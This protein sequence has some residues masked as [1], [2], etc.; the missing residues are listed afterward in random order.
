LKSKTTLNTMEFKGKYIRLIPLKMGHAEA[1]TKAANIFREIFPLS[2]VP[3][4]VDS[5][6]RCI[7][8]ANYLCTERS[9]IPFAIVE[10]FNKKI[11]G[12]TG[13]LNLE[14]WDFPTGHKLRRT[15][16][17]PT[18]VEIGS[19]YLVEPDQSPKIIFDAKLCLLTHAFEEWEVL[20]VAFKTDARNKQSRIN[21]ERIGAKF[22]GVIRAHRQ[23]YG[24]EVTDTAFYSIL[25][26]DWPKLKTRLKSKLR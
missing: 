7:Q 22:D 9:A 1:L 5:I 4:D 21:I 15:D 10:K 18:V 6:L 17:I 19:E 25:K 3:V 2:S 24:C 8:M 14:Y 20:R 13:F 26:S 16:K 11:I 12:S 23:D